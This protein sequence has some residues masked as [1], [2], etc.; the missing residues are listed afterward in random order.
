[1]FFWCLFCFFVP[2]SL[3]VRLCC[4]SACRLC[5]RTPVRRGIDLASLLWAVGPRV[6]FR[7][8]LLAGCLGVSCCYTRRVELLISLVC[9]GVHVECCPGVGWADCGGPPPNGRRVGCVDWVA[10]WVIWGFC[11][12]CRSIWKCRLWRLRAGVVRGGPGRCVTGPV[13][14]RFPLASFGLVPISCAWWWRCPGGGRRVA[15]VDGFWVC[16]WGAERPGKAVWF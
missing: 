10:R 4:R 9:V 8:V 15:T 13:E 11:G 6:A 16:C 5:P 7:R 3:P 1:M 12:F 2:P 14:L